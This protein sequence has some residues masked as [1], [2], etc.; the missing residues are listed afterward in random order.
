MNYFPS[1]SATTENVNAPANFS[2]SSPAFVIRFGSNPRRFSL[3]LMLILSVFLIGANVHAETP[4]ASSSNCLQ[5]IAARY[6]QPMLTEAQIACVQSGEE[7]SAMTK[8]LCNADHS[9][10]SG[11]FKIF[12]SYDAK[13]AAA[14]DRFRNAKDVASRTLAMQEMIQLKQDQQLGYGDVVL[15]P[16]NKLEG[17]IFRCR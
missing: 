7:S 17:D 4:V 9:D 8:I 5:I 12:L 16:L 3:K 1:R 13:I 11:P 2:A 6:R 15:P 14:T 10:R